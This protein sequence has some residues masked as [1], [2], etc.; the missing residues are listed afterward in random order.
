MSRNVLLLWDS[1]NVSIT[2]QNVHNAR[3]HPCILCIRS[4]SP[5][6]LDFRTEYKN[7][8]RQSCILH[9]VKNAAFY[10][11]WLDKDEKTESRYWKSCIGIA[12]KM[13]AGMLSGLAKYDD[14]F[15]NL[16]YCFS[17][18]QT[19]CTKNWF[20]MREMNVWKSNVREL[21]VRRVSCGILARGIVVAGAERAGIISMVQLEPLKVTNDV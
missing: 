7:T 15:T 9:K 5:P 16:E 6:N 4:A 2:E 20:E 12:L 13:K 3:I 21:G 8:H 1:N 18:L 19:F 11:R 17:I 14:C 10:K